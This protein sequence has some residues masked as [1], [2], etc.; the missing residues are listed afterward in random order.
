MQSGG[1]TQGRASKVL[2]LNNKVDTWLYFWN[3]R[4]K[5]AGGIRDRGVSAGISVVVEM[6]NASIGV[7]ADGSFVLEVYL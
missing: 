2:S 7:A 1:P 5:Y 3:L 6:Y 4:G